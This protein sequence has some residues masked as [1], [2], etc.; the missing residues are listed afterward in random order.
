MQ[1]SFL[2]IASLMWSI[3]ALLELEDRDKMEKFLLNHESK[4]NYPPMKEEE[5]I[6]EYVVGDK[7]KKM[8][9]KCK[10][11]QTNRS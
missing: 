5:T 6:F 11:K 10:K 7:G 1:L 9:I 8:I 4:Y 2:F 3:G